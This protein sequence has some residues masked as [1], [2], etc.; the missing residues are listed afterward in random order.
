MFALL[1]LV[2]LPCLPRLTSSLLIAYRAHSNSST[3]LKWE[4]F[5]DEMRSSGVSPDRVTFNQLLV[6]VAK[7]GGKEGADAAV[8]IMSRMKGMA[9]AC[10][11]LLS[12]C[13]CCSRPNDERL[14]CG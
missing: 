7:A 4:A 5:L 9:A 11:V 8:E 3:P 13:C 10:Q 6:G 14:T 12:R 2:A 1:T